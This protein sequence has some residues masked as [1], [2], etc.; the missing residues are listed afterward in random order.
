M[1]SGKPIERTVRPVGGT[2]QTRSPSRRRLLEYPIRLQQRPP[3][4]GTPRAGNPRPLSCGCSANREAAEERS[5]QV[6]TRF[7]KLAIA[8]M[9]VTMV[10]AG[11][12]AAMLVKQ[13]SAPRPVVVLPPVQ[14]AHPVVL[15]APAPTEPSEPARPL[16]NREDREDREDPVARLA[17]KR[18]GPPR[19]HAWA[20]KT[21]SHSAAS[22]PASAFG[23]QRRRGFA[24]IRS[25]RALVKPDIK[26]GA[27]GP[28]LVGPP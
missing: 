21:G 25:R 12:N 8:M 1:K 14:P 28:A 18:A 27:D 3:P 19:A 23:S 7:T 13:A 4:R 10:I 6:I 26:P 11:A 20:V 9:C 16:E 22:S 2:T 5:S 15:P 17:A 24:R